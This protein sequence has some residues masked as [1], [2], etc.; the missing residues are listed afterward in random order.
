MPKKK[1]ENF[2]RIDCPTLHTYQHDKKENEVYLCFYDEDSDTEY[3]LVIDG[4]QLLQWI[5]SKEI[6][7]IKQNTI[8]MVEQL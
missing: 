2:V 7:Q 1:D 3:T 8:K 4:Y 6:A 5:G